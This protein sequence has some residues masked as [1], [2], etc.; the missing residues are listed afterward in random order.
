MPARDSRASVVTLLAPKA[1]AA[2]RVKLPGKTP[3]VKFPV[4]VRVKVVTGVAVPVT[5]RRDGVPMIIRT[6]PAAIST[7]LPI[8]NLLTKF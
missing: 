2:P 3:P 1:P 6:N 5:N 8:T 7:T 4:D